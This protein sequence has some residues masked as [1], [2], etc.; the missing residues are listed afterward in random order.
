MRTFL[1]SMQLLVLGFLFIG[2][3]EEFQPDASIYEKEYVVECYIEHGP[4]GFPVYALVTYALPFYSS[5]GVDAINNAFVRDAAVSITD[6]QNHYALQEICL[7][8]LGEPLRSQW[9]MNLGYNP[10]SFK[11]NLCAYVDLAGGFKAEVGKTY[12]LEVIKGGDT[13][14]GSTIIPVSIPLDSIWFENPPGKNNNDTFAQMFCKI[15]DLP[16]QKDYY[17]YFTAGANERLIANLTSVTDD[18]FFDGQEFKFTL[19]EAIGPDETFGDNSGLFRRGDSVEVK[20]CT[21]PQSHFTFWST[22]ETSRTRQG[23]FANYVRI[24]GNISPGLG[25][26]GGQNC[27]YYKVYVPKI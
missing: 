19:S 11:T 25:I 26:F 5:F 27:T 3:E 16:G 8:D 18:V 12:K 10:D 4:S 9:I 20:W 24:Q 15:S 1:L 22:L 2:C 21:L 7:N 23:P 13:I 14:T 6:G 17:R